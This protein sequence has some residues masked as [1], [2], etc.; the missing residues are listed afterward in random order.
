[1]TEAP[2]S[3]PN[4][5]RRRALHL[6]RVGLF[7]FLLILIHLQ[8]RWY[9]EQRRGALKQPASVEQISPFYPEAA[10]LSDWD[11]GHGGQNV[12]DSEGTLLGYILQTSPEADN[13]IGFSGP[14][15]TLVAFSPQHTILGILVLRSDDTREHLSVILKNEGFL[16]Q[17]NGLEK[18]EAAAGPEI[19][20]VSGATLTSLSIADG[21]ATRLGGGSRKPRFPEGI[22]L[23]EVRSLFDTAVSLE[24]TSDRPNILEVLDESGTRIGYATRTSPYSDHMMGYQGPSD[25]LV[26]L[27]PEMRILALQLR[28]TYDNEPYV[29]LMLEDEYF[30]NTF[31]GF[32]LSEISQ[33]D[34]V[35]AGIDGVTGATKTSITVAESLVL[36][37]REH[38]SD[39]GPPPA[40][41]WIE[42]SGR[43][44]GTTLV[45]LAGLAIAFTGLRGN[46]KL[47]LVFQTV[48]IGY[49][50]FVNADMLSQALLVGWAQNGIAWRVAPGLVFLSVAAIAAPILTGRQVYCTHLCPYGAVQDWTA[51]RLPKQLAIRGKWET[52]LSAL[53]ALLL[54][55]IFVIAM[56]HLPVSLVG[57]EPFDAFVFRIAGWA[58]LS[59]AAIGLVA[60]LFIPRAYCRYGCPTGAMLKWLRFSAAS[61]RF[62][63][64]D[65]VAAGFALIGLLTLLL[66]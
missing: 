49:L 10:R 64:R 55:G 22:R 8:H 66:R 3:R 65:F 9:V 7:V 30:F 43:S 46:R 44:V 17:W 15:N 52:L 1:M 42:L 54:L 59:I 14:T 28:D 33:L 23:D 47:R 27:D 62:G 18:R 51:R 50:G 57:L 19:D 37:A 12:L 4:H 39:S 5:F 31:V 34:L 40:K 26:L 16:T 48:L 2:P 36:A 32:D 29:K 35:D 6:W 11:P 58:T 61:D 13:I 41:P 63:R 38:T 56:M 20:A 25:L 53:P 45:V 21:I 24:P 60:S